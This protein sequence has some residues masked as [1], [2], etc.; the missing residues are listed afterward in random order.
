LKE[1]LL[2][3]IKYLKRKRVDYADIRLV[4]MTRESIDVKNGVVEGLSSHEDK[5]FGI[6]VISNGGWGFA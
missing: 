4:S 5:G 3:T 2:E 1:Y 6:R